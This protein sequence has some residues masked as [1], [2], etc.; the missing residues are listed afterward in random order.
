MSDIKWQQKRK[1][2]LTMESI[3]P[4]GR[5]LPR[6]A[7]VWPSKASVFTEPAWG[8]SQIMIL[9]NTYCF[10]LNCINLSFLSMSALGGGVFSGFHLSHNLS[11]P[12]PYIACRNPS[13]RSMCRISCETSMEDP[14]L[15]GSVSSC[16]L[17]GSFDAWV[18]EHHCITTAWNVG[19]AT[20]Q[21]DCQYHTHTHSP[22]CVRLKWI[23]GLWIYTP[24]TLGS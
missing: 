6:Q 15:A 20:N 10:D 1:L 24:V 11:E 17:P 16:W 8:R 2:S 13:R 7:Q 9:I 21:Y 12:R 5:L 4:T 19:E 3:W 14:R 22:V 18:T 23:F